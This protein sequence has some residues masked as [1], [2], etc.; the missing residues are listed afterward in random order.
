MTAI[1]TPRIY[2]KKFSHASQILTSKVLL[3][4]C[5]KNNLSFV[6]LYYLIYQRSLDE[7]I[8]C[9]AY[10]A[11]Y[12]FFATSL[13]N[14]KIKEHS[15]KTFIYK[16]TLDLGLPLKLGNSGKMLHH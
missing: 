10:Q 11:L 7:K 4:S 1:T 16:R 6:L 14:S 12:R 9:E 8:K 2:G 15:C 13:I 3:E 5:D